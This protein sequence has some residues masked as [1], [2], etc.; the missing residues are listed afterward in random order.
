MSGRGVP[1]TPCAVL[2]LHRHHQQTTLTPQIT[3]ESCLI[4]CICHSLQRHGPSCAHTGRLP[5]P[6]AQ[7]QSRN[8]RTFHKV[9]RQAWRQG[10][11]PRLRVYQGH[12]QAQQSD[13]GLGF[14]RISADRR[15]RQK[16]LVSDARTPSHHGVHDVGQYC[17][18]GFHIA[19]TQHGGGEAQVWRPCGPRMGRLNVQEGSRCQ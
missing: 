11:Q 8:N 1:G 2:A 12:D 13:A 5:R 16:R 9:G 3:P 15:G 18:K 17:H 6:L 4:H 10:L 7:A 14:G 19:G